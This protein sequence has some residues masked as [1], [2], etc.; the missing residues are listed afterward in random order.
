MLV[1]PKLFEQALVGRTDRNE[2]VYRFFDDDALAEDVMRLFVTVV[3]GRARVAYQQYF[4]V[5][6]LLCARESAHLEYTS[7]Q[8]RLHLNQLL[9]NTF[10]ETAASGG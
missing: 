5:G 4:P 7:T 1:F 9:V 6:E 8:R 3:Q 2:K 10:S